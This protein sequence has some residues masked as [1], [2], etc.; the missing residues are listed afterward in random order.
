MSENQTP[1]SGNNSYGGSDSTGNDSS[2][3]GGRYSG[4]DPNTPVDSQYK[5]N[6]GSNGTIENTSPYTPGTESFNVAS[7]APPDQF[8]KLKELSD[9]FNAKNPEFAKTQDQLYNA[10]DSVNQLVQSSPDM[11]TQQEPSWFQKM[12]IVPGMSKENFFNQETPAQRDTRMGMVSN[13]IN[14]VGNAFTGAMMPPVARLGMGLY[15]AYKGYQADPNK[16]VGRAI[17][18]GAQGLPGYAGALANMYNGNYGAALTGGLAKNGVTGPMANMAGIGADY[19]SG[20]NIAP[21][22]GGL[23][24][25]FAG[26]SI[27]GPLGG[28]FGKSLGQF[29]GKSGSIRK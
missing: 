20:K 3:W 10:T 14:A 11:G 15:G 12:G 24:G 8:T 4:F 28:M 26:Q 9:M 2:A 18:T 13:G 22:L 5:G 19:A 7:A 1:D 21:S 25:Q 29:M 16:D 23:A 6:M 17:A 27:G